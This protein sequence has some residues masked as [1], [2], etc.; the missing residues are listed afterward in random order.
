MTSYIFDNAVEAETAD[1][2]ISLDALY[3]PRSFQFREATGIRSGWRCLEIGGGSGSVATW[4]AERVGPSGYV[5]VTD[6]DPRFIET[7]ACQK[8]NHVEVRRHDIGT[9]PLPEAAFDLIHARLVLL[10]VPQRHEALERLAR[11]LKPGGWL[12]IEEFDGRLFDRAIP[13]A[14]A[15]EAASFAKMMRVLAQLMDDR[16]FEAEWARGLYG[17]LKLAGLIEVGMDGHLAVREGGKSGANLDAANFAQIRKEAVTKGLITDREYL[18][19]PRSWA[20]D[21][22]A[23]EAA[24]L[25]LRGCSCIHLRSAAQEGRQGDCAGW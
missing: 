15:T 4:M 3:N 23:H 7:A 12:V 9:D 24:P 8:R 6:I 17:R 5:L 2:F 21:H 14:D 10:H 18:R 25:M 11:A 22:E 13:T 19:A 20:A 16:G 1:R